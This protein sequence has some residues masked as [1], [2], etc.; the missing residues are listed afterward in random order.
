[1]GE[2]SFWPENETIDASWNLSGATGLRADL[3]GQKTAT[4][5]NCH[6]VIRSA[7]KMTA[8]QLR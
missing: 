2:P 5:P 1:M 7:A 4:R 6:F 3:V 8:Q